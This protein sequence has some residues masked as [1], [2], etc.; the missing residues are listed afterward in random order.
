V[1]C[2]TVSRGF[3]ACHWESRWSRFGGVSRAPVD[4][5]S[6]GWHLTLTGAEAS[7]WNGALLHARGG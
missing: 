5:M 7:I 1:R 2:D 3:A 4:A 6:F